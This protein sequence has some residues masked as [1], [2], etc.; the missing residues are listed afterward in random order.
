M[1]GG[2]WT[3][4]DTAKF[5]YQLWFTIYRYSGE[6]AGTGNQQRNESFDNHDDVIKW[7]HFP[8]YWP[9]VRGNNRSPVN[10]PH[11]DKWRRTLMF[12]LIC[13]CVKGWANNREAGDL[14]RHRAHYDVTVMVRTPW[15]STS[16]RGQYVQFV[17]ITLDDG[18]ITYKPRQS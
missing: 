12:P 3:T 18:S 13:T 11:K 1:R 6:M 16:V 2:E 7:K 4:T 8:R 9:F 14:R 5:V 15:Q 10:S 17:L